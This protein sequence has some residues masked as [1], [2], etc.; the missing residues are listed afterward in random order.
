M[1]AGLAATTGSTLP[2]E[3][4]LEEKRQ[5][6]APWGFIVLPETVI[7]PEATMSPPAQAILVDYEAEVAAVVASGGRNLKAADV[8]FWGVTG[9]NDFS[10]RD[11][12]FKVGA[13]VDRGALKWTLQKNFDTANACGPVVAVDEGLSLD[14]VGIRLTV[15]GVERQHDTTAGM[16]YSF[17]EVVEHISA[18]TTIFPGDLIVSGTPPGVAAEHGI[19]G[20]YLKNGDVVEVEI[21]GVGKLRNHVVMTR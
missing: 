21:E 19:D 12:H 5:G 9:W 20:P 10:I 1:S 18:Y 6:L 13:S 17:A 4:F 8:T 11:P 3:H 2:P 7:G 16:I 15:N 14:H